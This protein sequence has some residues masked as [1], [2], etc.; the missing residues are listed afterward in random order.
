[1]GAE[2]STFFEDRTLHRLNRPVSQSSSF[3]QGLFIAPT[4]EKELTFERGL[5][6]GHP[7]AWFCLLGTQICYVIRLILGVGP[8]CPAGCDQSYIRSK[9]PKTGDLEMLNV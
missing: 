4:F 9:I 6:G 7:E 1:V 8:L 2:N 5:E 3:F